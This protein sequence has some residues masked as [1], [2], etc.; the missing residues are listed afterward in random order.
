MKGWLVGLA[1]LL[2]VTSADAQPARKHPAR[3]AKIAVSAT[4]DRARMA[5]A[6]REFGLMVLLY[7]RTQA[8][9]DWDVLAY[10][11]RAPGQIVVC[12]NSNGRKYSAKT[13]RLT[14]DLWVSEW[15]DAWQS[16]GGE[17]KRCYLIPCCDDGLPYPE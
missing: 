17:L 2:I 6:L 7:R 10:E 9:E 12:F 14:V 5:A 1:L 15:A 16:A 11:A 8:E 3:R 13:Q 4:K